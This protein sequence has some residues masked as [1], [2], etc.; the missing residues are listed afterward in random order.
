MESRKSENI[1][2]NENRIGTYSEDLYK[3]YIAFCKKKEVKT[4]DQK[5]FTLLFGKLYSSQVEHTKWR[6]GD[7]IQH[8]FLNVLLAIE[9]MDFSINR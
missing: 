4:I 5:Q 1:D 3:A 6:C 7:K 9:G 2:L 8:G